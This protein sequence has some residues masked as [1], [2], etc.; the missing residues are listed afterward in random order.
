MED[1]NVLITQDQYNKL[2]NRLKFLMDEINRI[3]EVVVATSKGTPFEES[4]NMNV[5]LEETDNEL[6]AEGHLARVIEHVL[7]LKYCTNNWNHNDWRVSYNEH[8]DSWIFKMK[9][10]RNI[11]NTNIINEIKDHLNDIYIDGIDWYDIANRKYNDLTYGRNFIPET[12]PWTLEELKD[13]NLEYLLNKLPDPDELSVQL[14][15]Y[16]ECIYLHEDGKLDSKIIGLQCEGN[17]DKY[18]QCIT[19]Y[20]ERLSS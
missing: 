7:K 1:K 8:Y 16:S 20:Y 5:F 9:K 13:K 17:C 6:S 2:M 4:W 11:F 14:Q 19:D 15:L 12:C 10:S 18:P 3:M